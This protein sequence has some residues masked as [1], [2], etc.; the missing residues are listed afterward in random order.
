MID[1]DF[2]L[3]GNYAV[4]SDVSG[5]S[6]GIGIEVLEGDDI[7]LKIFRDDTK[8]KREIPWDFIEYDEQ[9]T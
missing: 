7:S 5:E 3:V 9:S 6:G 2:P 8:E 4:Q 1:K